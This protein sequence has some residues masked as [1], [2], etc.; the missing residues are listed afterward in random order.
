MFWMQFFSFSQKTLLK[1]IIEIDFGSL[2]FDCLVNSWSTEM[3]ENRD[4]KSLTFLCRFL[5]QNLLIYV[6]LLYLKSNR[7]RRWDLREKRKMF[8]YKFLTSKFEFHW[9]LQ[10]TT[11]IQTAFLKDIAWKGYRNV[12]FNFSKWFF[13]DE[14]SKQSL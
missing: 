2:V 12:T 3:H 14:W 11:P 13:V 7:F 6:V 10:E 5:A 9:L 1:T 8:G 4:W